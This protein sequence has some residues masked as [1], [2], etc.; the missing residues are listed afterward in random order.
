MQFLKTLFWV[1]VAA[2]VVFFGTHNWTDVTL[3]LW[4]DILVDV[5]LPVLLGFTFLASFRPGCFFGPGSGRCSAGW[6]L[7]KDRKRAHCHR[8][9]RFLPTTNPDR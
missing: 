4:G 8:R 1:V 6:N 7:W 3:Q 2:L 9:V 5:K